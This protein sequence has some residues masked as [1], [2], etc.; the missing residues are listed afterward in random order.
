MTRLGPIVAALAVPLLCVSVQA[1]PQPNGPNPK[2]AIPA[3]PLAGGSQFGA[4]QLY[5]VVLGDGT[6]VRGAGVLSAT[7]L[8]TGNYEVLFRRNIT[9]CAWTG[10]VSQPNFGGSVGPS[11]LTM[12]GRSGTFT[13][14]F[15]QTFNSSGALTDLPFQVQVIC[16]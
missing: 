15:L 7:R 10:T 9:N 1:G 2:G 13:G 16:G 6:A 8:S 14:V 12:A 4:A 5:A 11:F 3:E